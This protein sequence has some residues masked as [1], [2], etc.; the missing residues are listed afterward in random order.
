MEWQRKKGILTFNSQKRI[1]AENE[2]SGEVISEGILKKAP[3]YFLRW[4]KWSVHFF[5]STF[6]NFSILSA[7]CSLIPFGTNSN[8]MK[9]PYKETQVQIHS[10]ASLPPSLCLKGLLSIFSTSW[11]D[12]LDYL[13]KHFTLLMLS[14]GNHNSP[15]PTY[16]KSLTQ[17]K[18]TCSLQFFQ[19][20][21]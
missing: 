16:I 15:L 8:H 5:A 17:G 4:Y 9:S 1:W 21:R 12:F 2:D 3:K 18:M 6:P 19:A 14:S 13:L 10:F 20:N 11:I 7:W